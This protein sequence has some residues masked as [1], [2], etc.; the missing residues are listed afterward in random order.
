[1]CHNTVKV[2][3]CII[4]G[5]VC[6]VLTR[7]FTLVCVRLMDKASCA[8]YNILFITVLYIVSMLNTCSWMICMYLGVKGLSF[9]SSRVDP[10]Q[11]A[12]SLFL[13]RALLVTVT[14]AVGV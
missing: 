1:M 11:F 12:T 6:N 13:S 10:S 14:V 8:F 2:G 9:S 5:G 7:L 3:G 4:L